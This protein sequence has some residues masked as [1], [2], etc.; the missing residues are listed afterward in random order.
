MRCRTCNY[1]LWN[2]KTR[3]CPECGAA[4]KPSEFE[5][6]PGSV[7]FHCP[8]CAKAYY[9]TDDRGHLVPRA[10]NCVGC[11]RAIDMDDM[12]LS[13]AQG[14]VEEQTIPL[15][16]PWATRARTGT[17]KAFFKTCWW[18]MARPTDL[19]RSIP[20]VGG[21]GSA[22]WFM[23]IVQLL[24]WGLLIGS[25]MLVF[26]LPMLFVASSGASGRA[27]GTMVSVG[28][29]TL[30]VIVGVILLLLVPV[31]A[32]VA[33]LILRGTGDTRGTMGVTFSS[34]C[35]SSG[36]N[37]PTGIPFV[38]YLV[39]PVWWLVSATLTVKESQRVKGGRAALAVL[40]FP[41]LGVVLVVGGYIAIVAFAV[42]A[43][44]RAATIAASS[45]QI[46]IQSASSAANAR[47]TAVT[48]IGQSANNPAGALPD[49]IDLVTKGLVAPQSL[50][51][52][53]GGTT[54]E[55]WT[56]SGIR[57]VDLPFSTDDELRA[58]RSRLTLLPASSAGESRLGDMVFTYR[59]GEPL[60]TDPGAWLL[61]MWP[62]PKFNPVEDPNWEIWVA[63]A[64][65]KTYQLTPAAFDA[66]LEAQNELRKHA[67]LKP[68]R[69]P[70]EVH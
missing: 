49:P 69:H 2:L 6:T 68:L 44:S 34:L 14:L 27:A 70:R 15:E 19:G 57:L 24:T 33:H 66:A 50:M 67:G 32:V 38:G 28:G 8:Y 18:A 31:W 61:I 16:L 53:G 5:F 35:Y 30:L 21:I 11:G 43:A 65:A 60:P 48:I 26:A 62:D 7:R 42:S 36:A 51:W 9:G 46:S 59:S 39:G 22:Y 52:K 55:A 56:L 58:L 47:Q 63:C 37:A 54:P 3:Q 4:F 20:Q 12:S 1:A 40:P 29:V 41:I 10:F 64:D 13:P 25:Y 45:A 23:L 17:I